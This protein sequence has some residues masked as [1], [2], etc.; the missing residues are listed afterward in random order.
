[1]HPTTSEVI[2]PESEEPDM[3]VRALLALDSPRDLQRVRSLLGGPGVLLASLGKSPLGERAGSEPFDLLVI[4]S[5]TLPDPIAE[6]LRAFRDLPS[7]PDVVVV[8]RREDPETRAELTAAGCLGVLGLELDDETLRDSLAAI[9]ERRREE[10]RL[11]LRSKPDDQRLG[12]FVSSSPSMKQLLSIARRVATSDTTLLI[13]GETGVG[14]EW[15]ARGIHAEGPRSGKPFLA[16]NCGAIPE[17]LLESELFGHKEGA[18]TG[19]TGDRRGH[20]ELAHGGTLFLDE[21]AEMPAPV[22]VK[23]LRV[24]QEKTIQPVGSERLIEI[25]VRVMAA[26]NR[27]PQEE[28]EAGRLRRDLYYR[29][30]V[31]TLS[32]PPLR[33]RRED[34]PDLV[35]NYFEIYRVRLGR[36]LYGIDRRAMTALV[37]YD[38]PGNVRELINVMERA[39]LLGTYEEV[40][41]D[42][43]PVVISGRRSAPGLA[44]AGPGG[45]GD[46]TLDEAWLEKPLREA[47]REAVNVFERQYLSA[48]LTRTGGRIGETASRVG[49]TPRA[50]FERM[51]QLGL[52]KEDYRAS[53]RP[54]SGR[55]SD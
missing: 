2:F 18:F 38:W 1:L 36:P 30:G 42:D 34:I 23:L 4:G 50:L 27:D 13:L 44:L 17:G 54:D 15:L 21:I 49:V 16:L 41:L 51:K 28:M 9:V 19:A 12:D 25:D 5:G 32:V 26:T 14:K 6:S 22:Q 33:E 47:R 40:T 37:E 24:L 39:V 52:H 35:S 3:L 11:R 8:S 29:L 46:A 43:L 53:S 48:W 10:S 45:A 20:F 55:S 31:V 7:S